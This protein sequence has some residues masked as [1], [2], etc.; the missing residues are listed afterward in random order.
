LKATKLQKSG[1]G[2][3]SLLQLNIPSLEMTCHQYSF[4]CHS[5]PRRK[6]AEMGAEHHLR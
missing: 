5:N 3:K 4:H 6:Q 2:E 1:E